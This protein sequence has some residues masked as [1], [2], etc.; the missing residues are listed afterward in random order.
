[1]VTSSVRNHLGGLKLL[2]LFVFVSVSRFSAA[3]D[4]TQEQIDSMQRLHTDFGER[5][6]MH[7]NDKRSIEFCPDNTCD[8]FVRNRAVSDDSMGD[9][10]YLYLYFFSDYYFLKEWR[11]EK[12]VAAAIRKLLDKR[13]Y[14][15]CGSPENVDKARCVERY[16]S[17]NNRIKLYSVRYDENVR[18]VEPKNIHKVT[19]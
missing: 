5:I 9:F 3:S 13:E 4:S 8:F 12:V 6:R 10:I 14:E 2:L 1:M 19:K 18:H 11:E 17:R 16:L 15:K 7:R